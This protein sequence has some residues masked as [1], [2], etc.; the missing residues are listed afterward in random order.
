MHEYYEN[1]NMVVFA[2]LLYVIAQC[3]LYL[4]LT[5]I[6]MFGNIMYLLIR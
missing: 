2:L 3:S 4:Q 1:E 6:Y 5:P